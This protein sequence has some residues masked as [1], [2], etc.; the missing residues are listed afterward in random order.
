[1]S[2][3][4]S[5]KNDLHQACYRKTPPTEADGVW[6]GAGTAVDDGLLRLAVSSSGCLTQAKHFAHEMTQ[7]KHQPN[8]K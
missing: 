3:P 8:P 7:A 1:L 5:K 2:H 6:F 4:W